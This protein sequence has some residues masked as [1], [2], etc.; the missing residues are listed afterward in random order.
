MQ[1]I[2]KAKDILILAPIIQI[3][4]AHEYKLME[5]YFKREA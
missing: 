3:D 1:C 2:A 5:E 4:P